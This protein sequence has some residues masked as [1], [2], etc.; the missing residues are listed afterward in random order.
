MKAAEQ[1]PL[2]IFWKERNDDSKWGK[3]VKLKNGFLPLPSNDMSAMPRNLSAVRD[4][5]ACTSCK[6]QRKTECQM[7]GV[8]FSVSCQPVSYNTPIISGW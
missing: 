1:G 3:A 5:G 6:S 7:Y 2:R 8:Q 4:D